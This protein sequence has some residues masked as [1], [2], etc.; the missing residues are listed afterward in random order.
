MR[1]RGTKTSVISTNGGLGDQLW[2]LGGAR[3]SLDLNF[4]H[5]KDLTDATTGSNLVDFTRA[6]SGTYVGSDGLIKTATTNEP[7]FDHDPTTGESL[8]L[9]VEEQ[10]TNLTPYS[11]YESTQW[12]FVAASLGA[13]TKAAIDG[14]TVTAFLANA[15]TG[16]HR[17]I[18]ALSGPYTAGTAF[19]FS[20]Y[21]AKPANSDIRGI[22]V[23][24]R[25]AVGGQSVSIAV[26]DNGEN[27]TYEF[28]ASAPFGAS[29]PPA[30]TSGSF[31]AVPVGNK[32]TRISIVTQ[33]SSVNTNYTQWDIGF[34]TALSSDTGT[35]TANSELFIDA[36]Q[37]EAGSFPT[38][39]IPTTSST[40]TR[41]ADVAS[42][43]G[44][45]FSGWFN[46]SE[47]SLYTAASFIGA[48]SQTSFIAQ[49]ALNSANYISMYRDG[50]PQRLTARVVAAGVDSAFFYTTASAIQA[51]VEYRN[52]V[53]YKLNDFAA[54]SNGAVPAGDLAGNVPTGL[55]TLG[56]GGSPY[57]SSVPLNGHLRRLTYWPARLPNE[58][59]QTIT[60]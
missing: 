5:S 6:S 19:T 14:A 58:T 21:V 59:L 34:S 51:D 49:A 47:G 1:L 23:R 9:L 41:A 60:Q 18:R 48:V 24:L 12:T 8:G 26:T 29:P 33:V 11:R 44:S 2:D 46:E 20:L 50:S 45:N 31:S 55:T 35:G 28:N 10:R 13:S 52:C 53:G 22:I 43:S 4:A 17:V 57:T 27:S 25:T 42:I 30:I 16:A 54:T 38:S 37:L 32:W 36:V 40:V 56:L 7:R 15:S 39:Y 3:P